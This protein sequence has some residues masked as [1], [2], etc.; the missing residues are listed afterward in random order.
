MIGRPGPTPKL[1]AVSVPAV[2]PDPADPTAHAPLRRLRPDEWPK[3]GA[4]W[5][6]LAARGLAAADPV[7]LMAAVANPNKATH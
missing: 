7:S 2:S 6:F 1:S 4:V 5:A 3:P